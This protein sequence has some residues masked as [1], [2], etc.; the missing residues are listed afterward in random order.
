[1]KRYLVF[2]YF[3]DSPQGGIKDLIHSSNSYEVAEDV[4]H[5]YEEANSDNHFDRVGYIY[6]TMHDKIIFELN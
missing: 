6:D 2:Y 5:D 3:K 1:M 4:L